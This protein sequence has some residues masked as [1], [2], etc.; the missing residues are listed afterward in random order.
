MDLKTIL[1]LRKIAT[2]FIV[3]FFAG[4]VGCKNWKTLINDLHNK[5]IKEKRNNVWFAK[6]SIQLYFHIVLLSF[7][8]ITS[9]IIIIYFI[10]N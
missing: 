2:P 10:F 4:F 8:N 6:K 5:A 7:V 3:I 9:W 1:V